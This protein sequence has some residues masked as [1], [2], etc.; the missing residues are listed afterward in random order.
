[1]IQNK[2]TVFSSFTEEESFFLGEVSQEH[3]DYKWISVKATHKG[4]LA[5]RV[6]TWWAYPS[7]FHPMFHRISFID[8]RLAHAWKREGRK[9]DHYLIGFCQLPSLVG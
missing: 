4:S 7:R 9:R 6:I 5:I 8:R 3:A 2:F 1:M